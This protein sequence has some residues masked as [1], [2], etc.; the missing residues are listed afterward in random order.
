ME[1]FENRVLNGVLK[2]APDVSTIDAAQRLLARDVEIVADSER[3]GVSDLWPCIWAL[4]AILER[5]FS[6]AVFIRCGLK[7]FLPQPSMLGSR[8]KFVSSPVEDTLKIGLGGDVESRNSDSVWGDARGSTLSYGTLIPGRE[9]AHPITSFALAGY[10][11]YT[12]LARA[13][14]MPPHKPSLASSLIHLPLFEGGEVQGYPEGLT[15]IGLGQLG[16]A[17]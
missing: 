9:H 15:F 8:C 1:V 4:A 13:V 10:L 3:S 2:F 5:Q 17:Y 11:G 14:R 16:Q 12:A 7:S 6:G